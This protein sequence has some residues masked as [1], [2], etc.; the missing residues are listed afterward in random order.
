MQKEPFSI[1]FPLVINANIFLDPELTDEQKIILA[2]AHTYRVQIMYEPD[3]EKK[4]ALADSIRASKF[5][6]ARGVS[7][8]HIRRAIRKMQNNEAVKKYASIYFVKTGL[9]QEDIIVFHFKDNLPNSIQVRDLKTKQ[10]IDEQSKKYSWEEIELLKA[11]LKDSTL[12]I[13]YNPYE[14]LEITNVSVN[15]LVKGLAYTESMFRRALKRGEKLRNPIGYLCSC[16]SDNGKFKYNDRHLAYLPKD[17]NV[18][19]DT[20]VEYEITQESFIYLD[21]QLNHKYNNQVKIL[22][23][24]EN[25]KVY[26]KRIMKAGRFWNPKN[27]LKKFDIDYKIINNIIEE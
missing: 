11:Y 27:W 13:D 8:D 16:F 5:A 15:E 14:L 17:Y 18:K 21:E 26:I 25:G 4:K 24:K 1:Y 2:L 19:I 23:R 12:F 6:A 22:Y 10:L 20:P 9:N 7:R 3:E